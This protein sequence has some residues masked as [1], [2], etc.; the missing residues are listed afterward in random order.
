MGRA[1]GGAAEAVTNATGNLVRHVQQRGEGEDE[2]DRAG[3]QRQQ[4]EQ[5]DGLDGRAEHVP[6]LAHNQGR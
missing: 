3:Q 5:D 1:G 2:Q 6:T 4:Q